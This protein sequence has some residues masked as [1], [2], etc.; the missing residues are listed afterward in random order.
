MAHDLTHLYQIAPTISVADQ[1]A[2][3]PWTQFMGI[4]HM[5]SAGLNPQP[6]FTIRP[7]P[8]FALRRGLAVAFRAKADNHEFSRTVP[9]IW[10]S[11]RLVLN[12][13]AAIAS[14]K[15]SAV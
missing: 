13:N 5:G 14:T 7:T 1:D 8:L 10:L 3:G 4:Y 9:Q 15:I 2:V 6:A 11:G 12:P